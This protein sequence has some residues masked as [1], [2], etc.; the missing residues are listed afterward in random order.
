MPLTSKCALTARRSRALLGADF[1]RVVLSSAMP[2]LVSDWLDK[3]NSFADG[4]VVRIGGSAGINADF[5]DLAPDA[6]L[7]VH[8]YTF[9]K[10]GSMAADEFA[11]FSGWGLDGMFSSHSDLAITACDAFVTAHIPEPGT[12]TPMSLGSTATAGLA[13]HKKPWVRVGM[14]RMTQ[15]AANDHLTGPM[16]RRAAL[17]KRG[18]A[19]SEPVGRR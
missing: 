6:G 4:V 2:A 9:N 19:S 16:R 7:L 10:T 1:N 14:C 18:C 11:K 8:G 15:S 12:W 17:R 13:R 3:I 5:I